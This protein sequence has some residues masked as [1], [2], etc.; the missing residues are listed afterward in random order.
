VLFDLDGVVIH[1]WGFRDQLAREYGITP[2]M[3]VAFF[4]GPFV[5][6]VEGRVDVLDALPP[7]LTAWGWQEDAA[8]FVER[9]LAAENAP[10][11]AVLAIVRALRAHGLPCFAASTQERRRAR[12][13]AHDMGFAT[14]FDGLFF[15]CDLGV[16]K[17]RPGY[18]AAIAAA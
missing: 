10:N 8:T 16:M 13:L 2:E 18:Y 15:S 12:Y 11:H 5:D 9:W 4:R 14:A 6:C 3:T 17:P 7:Y 1:P